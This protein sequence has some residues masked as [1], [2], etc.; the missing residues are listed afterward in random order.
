M[1]VRETLFGDL[2]LDEWPPDDAG[3]EYPWRVF[4]AARTQDAEKAVRLWR[5]IVA[6]PDLESR[7]YL[8]AWHFLREHGEQPPDEIA[9]QVLGLVV[10][11]RLKRGLDLLA[12]YA[13]R[14]ARYYNH[15]GGGIVV[16]RAEGDL[17]ELIDA[18][19]A[20]AADVVAQ[21]GPSD[22]PRRG[23]PPKQHVR[24]SFLTPSGLHFGE[25]PVK[26]LEQDPLG[27]LVIA[28][29]S[30]VMRELVERRA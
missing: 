26:A 23:P 27:G 6:A 1:D 4:V 12:V 3:D 11:M 16:E 9:K 14:S 28:G 17:A 15:A 20:A 29:A 25:G 10:E 21:I 2:P 5:E 19:L 13:D 30:V 24:L 8:Q 18:L 22:E 7:H